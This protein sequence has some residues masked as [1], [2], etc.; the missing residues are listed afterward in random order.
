MSNQSSLSLIVGKSI[1][2]EVSR[3]VFGVD[4][5][6]NTMHAASVTIAEGGT[7]GYLDQIHTVIQ[8]MKE[9]I[10]EYAEVRVVLRGEKEMN[11]VAYNLYEDRVKL[12]GTLS[13]F[14]CEFFKKVLE[15]YKW[16]ESVCSRILSEIKQFVVGSHVG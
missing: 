1:P 9:L 16:L 10:G 7:V 14:V 6:M 2:L 4:T 8:E 5:I 13:E 12:D 11:D 15:K 3:A